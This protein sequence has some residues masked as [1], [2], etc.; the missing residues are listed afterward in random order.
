MAGKVGLCY[1]IVRHG[2]QLLVSGFR[3][4]FAAIADV[5]A[6][7]TGHAV[8]VA[9]AVDVRYPGPVSLR[10]HHHRGVGVVTGH[11]VPDVASV[12]FVPF[13]GFLYH[14]YPPIRILSSWSGD[15]SSSVG[16]GSQDWATRAPIRF[17]PTCPAFCSAPL[18]AYGVL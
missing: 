4:L 5:D 3:Q 17:L 16:G 10:D 18:P 8:E 14:E 2:L 6:P 7:H 9:V 1:R 13:L 11:P 12:L 15:L